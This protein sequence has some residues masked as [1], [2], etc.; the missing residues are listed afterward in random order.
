MYNIYID[1]IIWI[2]VKYSFARSAVALSAVGLGTNGRA[3]Q[4][5]RAVDLVVDLDCGLWTPLRL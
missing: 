1:Q 2:M 5:M 4:L 3:D